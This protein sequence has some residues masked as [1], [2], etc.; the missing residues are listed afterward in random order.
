[1]HVGPWTCW[2]VVEYERMFICLG[3]I[4]PTQISPGGQGLFRRA[5]ISPGGQ[6]QGLVG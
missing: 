6:G 3:K 4:K 1:M 5:Q 2:M